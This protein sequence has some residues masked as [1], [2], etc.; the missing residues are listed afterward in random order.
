MLLISYLYIKE[1]GSNIGVKGGYF[2]IKQKD[3]LE[4]TVSKEDLESI[5]I[6]GNINISASCMRECLTRGIPINY[7]SST[8]IYWGKISS[9]K[10]T[11]PLRLKK[12]IY[13]FD[14]SDF[15]LT[16]AK[17]CIDAKISN[18][19]VILKRFQRS[20]KIDISKQINNIISAKNHIENCKTTEQLMGYEGISAREYFSGLSNLVIDEFKFN[21]RSKQP[22]KDPFNSML[23]LGYTILTNEIYGEIENRGLSPYIG[24]L[25]SIHDNHPTLASDMME[26]W[27]AIIVD[28]VVMSL[29]QGHEIKIEHFY[30]DTETKGVFFTN[31]GMKIF[32]HKLEDKFSSSANYLCSN[33]K[34]LHFRRGI[35]L[36]SLAILRAIMDKNT[37]EYIPITIR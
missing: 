11:K 2:T 23:S 8:G 29:I 4:E 20:N 19:L 25:H 14:D 10:H 6:L 5:T 33:E 31:E 36:Q 27:R 37:D 9:T 7:C 15:S 3:D 16:L 17:K 1:Q 30:T 12:Q 26:E 34:A 13:N 32:I 35:Y 28:S 21:G 24:F 22:P 18:Q